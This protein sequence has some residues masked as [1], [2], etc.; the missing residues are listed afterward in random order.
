MLRKRLLVTISFSF[1]IRYLYR[2]GLLHQLQNFA[3][4]VIAITW[5][6]EEL[7]NELR[8][9]GFEVHLIP[10]SK[11]GIVY[12]SARKR[13][14]F[15]FTFF[16]LNNS[17]RAQ[18]KYL[19]LFNSKKT[20]VLSKAR[21]IV[22]YA[23]FYLPGYTRKIF[24]KEQE[25]LVADTNFNG[26]LLLVDRLN[27][28]AVLTVTPFHAQ[29]D[30]LL[31]ACSHRN[32]QMIAAILSFDNITKRGWMPVNYDTYLVWNKYNYEQTLR[33]YKEIKDAS[34]VHV[35]GAAQFDF[36]FNDNNLLSKEAWMQVAGIPET[37][38]KIILY[39]GGPGSLFPNE[40]QYLQHILNAIDSG[41]IKGD[42]LVLFRCHP[43]DNL[44]KWKSF[45]GEHKNLVYDIS[46]TGKE[47]LQYSNIT[48]DD[49]KKL[50]STLAYT[51]V[52]INLCSTMTVDGSAYNK[53]QIG[54]YYDEVNP[55]KQ[56]LLRGMYYQ[57]HFK[58]II[59]SQ[60][61]L[62]AGSKKE[63]I[64]YINTALANPASVTKNSQKVLEEI[65]TY[66]DGKSTERVVNIIK[67]N[68][69]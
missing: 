29:E 39:A 5:N 18:D 6:E 38:R 33:I 34:R 32:K 10:E 61:L 51:D 24:K 17:K 53:P 37:D 11:K 43:V 57:E 54:P 42:P 52:H 46:W 58:P 68:L 21:T 45:I 48:I 55:A 13:I 9:D 36:Y 40:P 49:I 16:R 66:T 28:D 41:A 69:A 50:C 60:S 2:T 22:N 65:I 30:I 47:K 27:I 56:D 59:N 19:N 67:K 4:V 35:V 62:L 8:T 3:D 63:L 15:W 20:V 1:S 14:D 12:E 31:R 25:T 23:R 7:I 44:S 26:M 64:H